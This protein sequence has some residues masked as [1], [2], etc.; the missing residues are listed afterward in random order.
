M[1]LTHLMVF[2]SVLLLSHTLVANIQHCTYRNQWY[3]FYKRKINDTEGLV[4]TVLIVVS[5]QLS[6]LFFL[7]L[8]VCELT[9]RF[10]FT[11][12]FLRL[13]TGSRLSLGLGWC[14]RSSYS[15]RNCLTRTACVS[16]SEA[17]CFSN[18]VCFH[19]IFTRVVSGVCPHWTSRS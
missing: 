4:S 13:K 3:I 19:L 2:I 16:A 6:F 7:F 5:C 18:A 1:K 12:F 15:A 10:H 17:L 8:F 11:Q 14:L 9:G